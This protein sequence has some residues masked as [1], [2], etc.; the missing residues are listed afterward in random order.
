M[1]RRDSMVQ[2]GPSLWALVTADTHTHTHTHAHV[3]LKVRLSS[4]AAVFQP[5]NGR[6]SDNN[7]HAATDK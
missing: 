1:Q 2:A 4:V 5:T 3:M 6:I 7:I